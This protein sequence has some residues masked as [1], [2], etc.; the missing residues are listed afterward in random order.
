MHSSCPADKRYLSNSLPCAGIV[1]C[2][3][4]YAGGRKEV[5]AGFTDGSITNNM[6]HR[7][8]TQVHPHQRIVYIGIVEAFPQQSN[9]S[10]QVENL[11]GV[12]CWSRFVG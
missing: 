2:A 9:E 8:S 10:G 5:R 3:Y 4:D 11:A 7:F 12:T 6:S 1:G